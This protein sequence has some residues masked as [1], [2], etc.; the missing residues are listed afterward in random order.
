MD[1]ICYCHHFASFFSSSI[2]HLPIRSWIEGMVH[3]SVD[4]CRC[5]NCGHASTRRSRSPVVLHS[6]W[7]AVPPGKESGHSFPLVKCSAHFISSPHPLIYVF[8][9]VRGSRRGHKEA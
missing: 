9:Y 6:I 8:S 3:T 7:S 2:I 4:V 5:R 1:W